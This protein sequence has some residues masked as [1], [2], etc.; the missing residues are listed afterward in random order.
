M[1]K[2]TGLEILTIEEDVKIPETNIILEKGD[3]IE[4]IKQEGNHIEESHWLD[5]AP[6]FLKMVLAS[7]NKGGTTYLEE[8]LQHLFNFMSIKTRVVDED[9]SSFFQKISDAA[10]KN[11][12]FF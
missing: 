3:R 10:A 4:I 1:N 7:H 12:S 6:K 5:L 8:E 9:I 11:K 2:K